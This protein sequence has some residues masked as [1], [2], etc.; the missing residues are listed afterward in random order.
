MIE[1][2]FGASLAT[3]FAQ[4]WK[5]NGIDEKAMKTLAKAYDKHASAAVLFERHKQDTDAKL[6]KL[7]NRKKA[8]LST[9]MS[10]FIEIYQ[11]IRAI[12]FQPGDG[13]LE[14]YANTLSVKQVGELEMMTATS[15]KPMSEKE[16]AVKYLFTGLGGMIL[17]DSKRNAAIANN[18]NRI[19]N[20]LYAQ[21][22]TLVIAVDALGARA[23]QMSGLLARFGM[24]FGDCI[25][26][27]AQ[28]IQQNGTDRSRY[29][30]A[31]RE[32]LMNCVNLAQAIKAVLDV[33]V[34]NAD[35]S[36]TEASL[37]ALEDGEHR[38]QE[39]QQR[40]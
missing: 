40:A 10:Q 32:V 21:A 18:Q 14:L 9:R 20:T 27:T 33:P 24:L 2:I 28:L 17:A 30:K 6:Q 26:S 19:A 4:A 1:L 8:I 35:G 36:V 16:L 12:D 29:S 23:E 7:V 11:Q 39:L 34:L 3:T 22:E 38:L 25:K 5:A 13:I 15:M 37:V 31:D